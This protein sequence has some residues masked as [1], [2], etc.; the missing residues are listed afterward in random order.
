MTM[1]GRVN[2]SASLYGTLVKQVITTA[3]ERGM[4]EPRL[5]T[6]SGIAEERLTSILAG[7]AQEVTLRELA[8][9]SLALGVSLTALLADS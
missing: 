9:L 3:S 6:D 5:A 7:Q 2:K 4:S 1:H 8:G